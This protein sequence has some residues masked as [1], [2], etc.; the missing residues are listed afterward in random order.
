M[1]SAI[2]LLFLLCCTLA[3]PAQAVHLNDA[4]A[5]YCLTVY[6]EAKD[7]A[8]AN[9]PQLA[10][11]GNDAQRRWLPLSQRESDLLNDDPTRHAAARAIAKRRFGALPSAPARA[12]ALQGAYEECRRQEDATVLA[13]APARVLGDADALFCLTVYAEAKEFAG[14]PEEEAALM[15][16]DAETRWLPLSQRESDLL[17]DDPGR[18]A[19]ASR[20]AKKRLAALP[21]APAARNMALHGAYEECR[22]LEDTGA[23]VDRMRAQLLADRRFC[24]ELMSRATAVGPRMRSLFNPDELATLDETRRIAKALAK[25]LPGRALSAAEDHEANRLLGERRALFNRAVANWVGME[26]P[27][28]I[29]LSRCHEDYRLGFLGGPNVL[30][31]VAA[32]N[33]PAVAAPVAAKPAGPRVDLGP[34]FRMREGSPGASYEGIWRQR[35]DSNVYD[36]LW[37]H[38]TT[39]DVSQDVLEVRGIENGELVIAREGLKGSY[40]ARVKPDGTLAPGRASWIASPKYSWRPLPPQDPR[41]MKLGAV[42]H[43]RELTF[44]GSQEGIWRRRGTSNVYDALWV[45]VPSGAEGRVHRAALAGR[46]PRAGQRELGAGCVVPLAG[47]AIAAGQDRW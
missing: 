40:R 20:A 21:S 8:G 11:M 3:V 22:R 1:R 41:G 25:P 44:D 16:M 29:E 46:P 36:G 9:E 15:G 23:P 28:V 2:G 24:R 7:F 45:H 30:E 5:L 27:M 17:N 18:H 47:G 37:V 31:E 12:A 42:L 33:A 32:A 6:A 10:L 43:M 26:D 34:V 13:A 19:V 39:G 38:T 35:G 14:A 4:D